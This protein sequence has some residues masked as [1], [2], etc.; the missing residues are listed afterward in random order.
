M[1]ISIRK[2]VVELDYLGQESEKEY[3][4]LLQCDWFDLKYFT[5]TCTVAHRQELPKMRGQKELVIY[6]GANVSFADIFPEIYQAMNFSYLREVDDQLLMSNEGK[7][8]YV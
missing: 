8:S 4:Q 6:L 3:T 1:F 5:E 2:K 7:D